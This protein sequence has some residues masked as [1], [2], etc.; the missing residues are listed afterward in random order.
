MHICAA[1]G[2]EEKSL[3]TLTPGG[4]GNRAGTI[5]IKLSTEVIYDFFVIS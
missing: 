1:V 2:D 5:V 3:K 4:R